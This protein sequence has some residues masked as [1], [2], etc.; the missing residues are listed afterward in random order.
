MSGFQTSGQKNEAQNSPPYMPSMS[1]ISPDTQTINSTT[2][3][4]APPD[5]QPA[6][7]YCVAS[8]S[9]RITKHGYAIEPVELRYPEVSK[10][11]TAD[12]RR[13]SDV[14][15]DSGQIGHR[16]LSLIRGFW[17]QTAFPHGTLAKPDGHATVTS[18]LSA[19]RQNPLYPHKETYGALTNKAKS[20][21]EKPVGARP[22]SPSIRAIKKK[23]TDDIFSLF[24]APSSPFKSARKSTGT[25]QPNTYTTWIPHNKERIA[26]LITR[27]CHKM[28]TIFSKES[29]IINV[30]SPCLVLG[31]IHGNLTDL[32]TYERSLW[33]KAPACVSCNYLFLGDYVDRGDYSVECVLYLFA[34]KS[35]AP[36]RFFL[37][38]GNHEVSVIQRQYTFNKEC[39]SKFGT[40][41]GRQLWRTFN[42]VF[43]RMPVAAVID[44]QIFCAHGGIPRAITDI[45][46][47]AREIPTPLDN[48]EVQC[49]AA[50][51]ILWNDPI[52]DSELIAMIEMDNAVVTQTNIVQAQQS[53]PVASTSNATNNVASNSYTNAN[54]NELAPGTSATASQLPASVANKSTTGTTSTETG[55][56]TSGAIGMSRADMILSRQPPDA[57][58]SYIRPDMS[59]GQSTE[60]KP[61]AQASKEASRAARDDGNTLRTV[62]SDTS[63]IASTT[64]QQMIND[65][66]VANIKRGTAFLFSDQAIRNFLKI[67]NLSHVIR[68]HEVIPTGFAFHGDGRVITI[69]SSSKYC[70][71]NN[72]AA[73]AYVDGSR[74][75]ILRLDTGDAGE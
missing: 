3:L 49:P 29:R 33:P 11:Q 60:A 7:N 27:L 23:S 34:M 58:S 62:P 48:P 13:A 57:L 73:C 61:I 24:S 55:S 40:T 14:L 26:D 39:E 10:S 2:S 37:L 65:G 18:I 5:P 19:F 46:A 30:S 6:L 54:S 59:Q 28:E 64:P 17:S 69:F 38:R 52:T 71:L 50:W 36:D 35:I 70:G 9:L 42:R 63:S 44:N 22:T 25:T 21:A 75:R 20:G 41:S 47:L 16:I 74:I 43:D 12:A 56:A 32:R 4:V 66:F 1:S 51:E 15:F 72:Q 45:K 31:D 53:P 8:H 68:A 67:N